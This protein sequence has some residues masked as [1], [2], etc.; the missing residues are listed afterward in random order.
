[1]NYRPGTK[2]HRAATYRAMCQY[3]DGASLIVAA[4]DNRIDPDTL[5]YWIKKAGFR[6]RTCT[7][8][9]STSSTVGTHIIKLATTESTQRLA[10]LAGTSRDTMI[11]RLKIVGAYRPRRVGQQPS[12]RWA[13]SLRNKT[14]VLEAVALRRRGFTYGEIAIKLHST[15]GTVGSWC[16][17]YDRRGFLWQQESPPNMWIDAA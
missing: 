6:M 4:R 2:A 13:N 3:Q 14:L 5:A 12:G 9:G 15:P 16:R 7:P 10:M 17:R 11:R 8:R 1:M